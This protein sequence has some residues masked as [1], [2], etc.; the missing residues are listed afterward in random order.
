MKSKIAI[1]AFVLFANNAAADYQGNLS[2]Y[3]TDIS[4]VSRW[5]VS[6]G[7]N[8]GEDSEYYGG[9]VHF[10]PTK[11]VLLYADFGSLDISSQVPSAIAFPPGSTSA[12]NVDGS[13]ISFGAV[14]GLPRI[15][16]A[17]WSTAIR[18]GYQNGSS[19]GTIDGQDA[20]FDSS[21]VAAELLIGGGL[22]SP[23]NLNWYA[24]VGLSRN[25]TTAS[26]NVS[27]AGFF[28]I[29]IENESN[30]TET[31]VSAG[32]VLPFKAV[33]V[34][35]GAENIGSTYVGAGLRFNIN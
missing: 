26:F 16:Q 8:H 7:L 33:D 21:V 22:V 30:E 28:Q 12:V 19:D 5:S 3:N 32:I 13:P 29:P 18:V 10:K 17:G 25:E 34:Y 11:T 27:I 4:E 31:T 2:S 35:L 20:T 1:A 15:Q 9:R 24:G 6:L 14:I 23:V